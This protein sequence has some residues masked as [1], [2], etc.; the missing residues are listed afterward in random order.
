M[1]LVLTEKSTLDCAHQGKV[2]LTA[3][4]QKLKVDGAYAIVS[5]GLTG[6]PISGC[7][8]PTVTPPATPS[9]PCLTVLTATGGVATKLKVNGVGVLLETVSGQTNGIVSGSPATW[10][11]QSAG[12][13]KLKAT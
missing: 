1:A 5:G 6:A 11:V 7:P 12:Q 3:T 9:S 10:S 4:Q 2:K 13:T 8:T